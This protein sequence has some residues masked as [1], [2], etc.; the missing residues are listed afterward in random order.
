MLVE[1]RGQRAE[2]R[3]GGV[4]WRCRRVLAGLDCSGRVMIVVMWATRRK[5][6]VIQFLGD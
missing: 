2:G 6:A 5:K 1:G 3:G 4:R